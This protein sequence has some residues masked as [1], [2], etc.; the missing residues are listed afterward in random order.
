M[1]VE[2]LCKCLKS[3]RDASLDTVLDLI[4]PP[5]PSKIPNPSGSFIQV[6]E[7][8]DFQA[9]L[10]DSLSDTAKASL[11]SAVKHALGIWEGESDVLS[12]EFSGSWPAASQV[13]A[14]LDEEALLE[15]F[16]PTMSREY[17]QRQ[18]QYNY[19]V[20]EETAKAE[21]V[22]H[23]V[24]L[25]KWPL[26]RRTLEYVLGADDHWYVYQPALDHA[27]AE[28]QWELLDHV[29]HNAYDKSVNS[30]AAYRVEE[31][32][33]ALDDG[34]LEPLPKDLETIAR[35]IDKRKE[36]QE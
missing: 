20:A 8:R 24:Q 23:A 21:V 31:T 32:V 17:L 34:E 13:L 33:L 10:F 3:H 14:F 28:K 9:S 18:S 1:V 2:G 30:W 35:A 4:A 29:A 19:D 26:L 27:A 15:R 16:K 5:R 22:V 7:F 25:D 6:P 12:K 36:K 11:T